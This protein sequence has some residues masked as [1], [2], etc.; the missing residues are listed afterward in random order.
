MENKHKP[1]QISGSIQGFLEEVAHP[2]EPK[3]TPFSGKTGSG[4]QA[5]C[6]GISRPCLVCMEDWIKKPRHTAFA[7]G[8]LKEWQV[9]V[10][11]GWLTL[12]SSREILNE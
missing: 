1:L 10:A 2:T 12:F 6:S 9:V 8:V 5:V 3:S 7:G 11:L 4:V